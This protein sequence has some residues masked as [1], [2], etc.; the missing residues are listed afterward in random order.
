MEHLTVEQTTYAVATLD[1]I[2]K[3]RDYTQ[4][5]LEQLSGVKQSQISKI[6]AKLSDPTSEVL[7][8]LFKALGLKLEDILH[9]APTSDA[10]E[11]LGYLATPLTAVVQFDN[12]NSELERVVGNEV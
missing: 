8:K 10:D 3:A 5:Q 7:V 2:V 12:Q 4:T 9:E 1:R 6:L 11:L